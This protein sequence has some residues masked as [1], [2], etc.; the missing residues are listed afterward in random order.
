MTLSAEQILTLAPDASSAS[1]GRQLAAESNWSNLGLAGAAVWGECKGSGK[2]PYRTQIDLSEPAFKCS[3]PSRKFPCKHGLGLYLLLAAN[4]PLFAAPAAQPQW[5]TDWHASRQQRIE[6]KQ[7]SAAQK[8]A[9]ATPE[10]LAAA[11][12]RDG[13]RAA[14]VAAGLTELQTW[15]QDLAREGFST[16]RTRG[17]GYWDAIAARMVDAQAGALGS[18]LRRASGACFNT[19]TPDWDVS[20][21]RDMG[22]L[23][24]LSKACQRLPALPELLQQ[25]VRTLV[26]WSV[27]QDDVL[28]ETGV[29]DRWQVLAQSS[30]DE[31][32]IK[33][34]T[35]WLR[36]AA[37]GRW[38][39]VIQF[40]VGT[41]GFDRILAAGTEFDGELVFYPG[42]LPL[43]A[44]IKTQEGVSTL[45]AE[46]APA[47]PLATL[48]AAY[49]DALAVNPFLERFPM[50]LD[51][52]SPRGV[53]GAAVLV[54]DDG[55]SVQINGAFSSWWQLLA[56]SGG[57]PV[58]IMGEWDGYELTPLSVMAEGRLY[59]FESDFGA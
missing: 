59:N 14:K 19:T 45:A 27:S 58:G 20:L 16:L 54:C 56:V 53:P 44:I 26:G 33:M 35:T 11:E 3:C 55:R 25:D 32:R 24:L 22:A 36:G 6:K 37:S 42:A 9:P 21:A 41:Q 46:L 40:A 4:A 48:L 1:S 28:R 49:A 50:M 5:V 18:R 30:S 51:R 29:Q 31:E 12:K 17:P 47:A 8:A 7:E 15:M 38:A 23:Y 34:R 13:K 57:H 39:M 43:R 52:V 2:N 10:Q